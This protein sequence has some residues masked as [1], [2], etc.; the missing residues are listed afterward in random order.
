M[1][2]H[3]VNFVKIYFCT[4][5]LHVSG[6]DPT[7]KLRPGQRK[8]TKSEVSIFRQMESWGA[9]KGLSGLLS[10]ITSNTTVVNTVDLLAHCSLEEYMPHGT[11]GHL[12]KKRERLTRQQVWNTKCHPEATVNLSEKKDLGKKLA[13]CVWDE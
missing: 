6:P 4:Y 3:W 8:D 11:L 13:L 10:E 2:S 9:R 7:S 5:I 12:R 1:S